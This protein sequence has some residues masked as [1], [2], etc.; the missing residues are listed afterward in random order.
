MKSGP[1]YRDRGCADYGDWS[2]LIR[3]LSRYDYDKA[4]QILCWPVREALV[5]FIAYLKEEATKAYRHEMLVYASLA[6]HLKKPEPP[7]LPEI[8]KHG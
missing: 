1:V 7:K 5:A 8:L 4:Q 3:E 2:Q 6:P